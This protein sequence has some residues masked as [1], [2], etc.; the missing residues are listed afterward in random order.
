[1]EWLAERY[2]SVFNALAHKAFVKIDVNGNGVI[3]DGELYVGLLLSYHT[4]NKVL[5]KLGMVLDPPG[6]ESVASVMSKF[7]RKDG[8]RGISEEEFNKVFVKFLS[9]GT[10]VVAWGILR[11]ILL[12]LVLLPLVAARLA[13][14]RPFKKVPS[15]V[16]A[17]LLWYLVALIESG[18][19]IRAVITAQRQAL[20]RAED[21]LRASAEVAE[22][23]LRDAGITQSSTR[24]YR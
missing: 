9:R 19:I 22:D 18:F 12:K 6:K 24:R 17:A 2:P 21:A 15:A 1:M 23:F 20:E 13:Q 3:E 10:V 7:V 14:F 8:S 5:S 4:L 16:L 11:H